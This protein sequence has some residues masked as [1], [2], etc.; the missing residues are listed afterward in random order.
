MFLNPNV[1]NPFY[2]HTN[3]SHILVYVTQFFGN[4]PFQEETPF[5]RI[6]ITFV[7]STNFW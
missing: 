6:T 1:V 3:F 7:N 5:F 4:R 2:N